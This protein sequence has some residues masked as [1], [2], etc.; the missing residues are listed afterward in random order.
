MKE[1]VGLV[2]SIDEHI[3]RPFS[4]VDQGFD[5]LPGQIID[6]LSQTKDRVKVVDV[7]GGEEA[8]AASYISKIYRN[9]DIVSVDLDTKRQIDRNNGIATVANAFDLNIRSES[10]D[11]VYSYWL[12][13]YFFLPWRRHEARF[14]ALNEISRVLKPDGIALIFFWLNPSLEGMKEACDIKAVSFKD[15]QFQD[16]S[17]DT[18]AFEYTLESLFIGKKLS[19]TTRLGVLEM[20]RSSKKTVSPFNLILKKFVNR[21]PGR[22]RGNFKDRF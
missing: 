12:F 8:R 17:Q 18:V 3:N 11:F 6:Y 21:L 9:V 10:I 2:K 7:G 1:V 13:P 4:E 14:R 19:H 20:I 22:S 5:Y 16:F 15:F